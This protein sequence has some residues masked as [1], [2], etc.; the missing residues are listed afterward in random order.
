MQAPAWRE[1]ADGVSFAV[2]AAV[3]VLLQLVFV[4]VAWSKVR[5]QK[6]MAGRRSLV[7]S[8]PV[9]QPGEPG[10]GPALAN[11]LNGTGDVSGGACADRSGLA[12]SPNGDAADST[13]ASDESGSD[14]EASTS[15]ADDH[16]ASRP[17]T[18]SRAGPRRRRAAVQRGRRRRATTPEPNPERV[19]HTTVGRNTRASTSARKRSR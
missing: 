9:A 14:E 7:L 15:G 3:W 13:G 4:A 6:R 19:R 17:R 12:S 16:E 8:T 5:L 1:R 11:G 10:A 18:R 2:L